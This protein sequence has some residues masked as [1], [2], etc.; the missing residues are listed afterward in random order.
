R[1]TKEVNMADRDTNRSKNTKWGRFSKVASLWV[2][3]F[4]VPMVLFQLMDTQEPGEDLSYSQLVREVERQN[5][6]RVVFVEGTAVEGELRQPIA[7]ARGNVTNFRTI[8][9]VRD[10]ETLVET[11]AAAGV[12]IDARPPDRDWWTI[13]WSILPWLL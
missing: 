13:L 11:L 6:E 2:L 1:F 7:G 10:S 5:V 12:T 3:L 9:P 8:L 4:L